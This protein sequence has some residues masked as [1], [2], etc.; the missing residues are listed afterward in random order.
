MNNDYDIKYDIEN[1]VNAT[2]KKNHL[3]KRQQLK[4]SNFW[5]KLAFATESAI[6]KDSQKTLVLLV[7]HFQ[8]KYLGCKRIINRTV[9]A[10]GKGPEAACLDVD[11]PRYI[12]SEKARIILLTTL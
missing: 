10:S 7:Q 5:P 4:S 1:D 3:R 6:A 11:C 9:L 12:S 8:T 2:S